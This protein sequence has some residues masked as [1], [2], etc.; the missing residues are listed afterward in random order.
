MRRMRSKLIA[1]STS[2]AETASPSDTEL[3]KLLDADPA[4]YALDPRYSL[5]QVYLGDD[6]PQMRAEAAVLLGK[7]NA[8]AP[9]DGLGTSAPIP[10]RFTGTPSSDLAGIFGDEFAA[11]LRSAP[12]GV[13][14]GPIA[15]GLGFHLVKIEVRAVPAAPRLA[16]TR[17]R[18][19]ND[20]RS[21]AIKRAEEES[22]R[23]LLEGYDVVIERPR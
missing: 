6:S 10:A 19:E 12:V 8:G 3:Q 21:A 20:W 11:A 13:W 15:S 22:F 2:E 5:A 1:T 16:D 7:L 9:P 17:Q 18:L 23:Q 4:R 14:T